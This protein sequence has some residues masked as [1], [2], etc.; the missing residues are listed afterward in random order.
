MRR[1]PSA[2]SGDRPAAFRDNSANPRA[3]PASHGGR[4][5]FVMDPLPIL[6]SP[7]AS[8]DARSRA[9][10]LAVARDAAADLVSVVVPT[11]NAAPFIRTTLDSL[12]AQTHC[13][14]E[15]L[16]V[17]DDSTD[18]TRDVVASYGDRVR[19]VVQRNGGVCSA[20][21]RGAAEARGRFVCFCDHDDYWYPEKL[22]RQV[23]AFAADPGLGVVYSRF[24]RWDEDENGRFASP[25]A[26]V[27][28]PHDE[29]LDPLESG[30]IYHRLLL[31]CWVL[32]S[33]AM[34]RADVLRDCGAFDESLPY[35]EDWDLWLRISRKY[36]FARLA[37][38]L[39]LYRQ[40]RRQGSR[41]VRDVDYRT[42][43]LEDAARRWGLASP[44]G[45]AI[46][47]REFNATL[48]RYHVAYGLYRLAGNQVARAWSSF[49]RGWRA[50]PRNARPLAY[51][52]LSLCGWRPNWNSE[53]DR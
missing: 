47:R 16:V 32:T 33:S 7:R 35:G 46:S 6:S 50:A 38:P 42:R 45:S 20:R 49:Y 37:A 26:I 34:I 53:H 19:L 30:W 2:R 39:V 52:L 12:L 36:R 8:A 40:H 28:G 10:A 9:T 22:A 18:A 15:I 24:I 4:P 25:S 1:R 31:D 17:D 11:Y 21:N 5:D 44:D 29:G 51:A 14:V 41:V 48:S 43:I 3:L 13:D 27:R 23:A